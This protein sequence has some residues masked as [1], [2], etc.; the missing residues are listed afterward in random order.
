MRTILEF[1]A[2]L[3]LVLLSA[4]TLACVWGH[5]R[6]WG[7]EMLIPVNIAVYGTVAMIPLFLVT[8][9]IHDHVH[10]SFH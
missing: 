1:F 6:G 3:E 2:S 8:A 5:F 9:F 10:F 7:A 4:C